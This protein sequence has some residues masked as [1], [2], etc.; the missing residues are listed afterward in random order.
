MARNKLVHNSQQQDVSVAELS[1]L[2][3]KIKQYGAH[4]GRRLPA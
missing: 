1:E 3:G 2:V 4:L